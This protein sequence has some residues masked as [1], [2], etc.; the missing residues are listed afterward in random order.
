MDHLAVRRLHRLE[1]LRSTGLDD[2]LGDDDVE[3]SS[4]AAEFSDMVDEGLRAFNVDK[5]YGGD[6]KGGSTENGN[7]MRSAAQAIDSA[8]PWLGIQI[9][10][11]GFW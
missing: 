2:L 11:C 8:L 6:N 5:L 1:R 9:G 4:V 10:G 7:D 3:R